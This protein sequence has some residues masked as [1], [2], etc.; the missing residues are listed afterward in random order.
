MNIGKTKKKRGRPATGRD[1]SIT[2]RIPENVISFI[3]RQA[4]GLQMTRSELI[5][6]MIEES[7]ELPPGLV[8]SRTAYHEAGHAVIGCVLKLWIT[9]ASIRHAGPSKRRPATAGR[10]HH[11]RLKAAYLTLRDR[12]ASIMMTMAGQIAEQV[13]L[14]L[15]SKGGDASDITDN[16]RIAKAHFSQSALERLRQMTTMLIWRHA[17]SIK[18]AASHLIRSETLRRDQIDKIIANS[19]KRASPVNS[20]TYSIGLASGEIVRY[21]GA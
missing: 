3:D 6:I 20:L 9:R 11:R 7:D 13:L 2:I 17:E 15:S 1:P 10:V 14:G 21:L 19:P 12:R 8:K 16:L 4:H 5:R 18:R